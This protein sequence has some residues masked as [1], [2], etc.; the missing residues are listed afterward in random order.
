MCRTN[1][2]GKKSHFA[3]ALWPILKVFNF[4]ARVKLNVKKVLKREREEGERE[5]ESCRESRDFAI[6]IKDWQAR[7]SQLA[8]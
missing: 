3:K 1:A 6:K 7:S 8:G 5:G 4:F 2:A